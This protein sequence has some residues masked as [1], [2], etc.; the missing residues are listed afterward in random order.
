MAW[1]GSGALARTSGMGNRSTSSSVAIVCILAAALGITLAGCGDDSGTTR[2]TDGGL[3]DYERLPLECAG[4]AL[5]CSGRNAFECGNGDGC[6]QS[7][8]CRGTPTSVCLGRTEVSCRAEGCTWSDGVGCLDPAMGDCSLYD[9]TGYSDIEQRCDNRDGCTWLDRC[10]G[11]PDDC[12]RYSVSECEDNLCRLGCQPERDVCND[13]CVDLLI[14][15]DHCGDCSNA[16][17]GDGIGCVLGSCGCAPPNYEDTCGVCD[18]DPSNDC[19]EDCAGVWGGS[20]REDMCGT[21]DVNPSNDCVQDCAGVW[22]GSSLMDDC[23]TCDNSA[24]NDCDCAGVPGGNST[25]D[26][27]GVCDADPMNDCDCSGVP[28][29]PATLDNCGVCDADPMN[30]CVQDCSGTWGGTAY[31]DPCGICDANPG[32][33][34][35]PCAGVGALGSCWYLG[36]DDESCA[37][38]CAMH[39]AFD[40]ATASIAGSGGSNGECQTVL[41]ALGH[42]GVVVNDG[43][44]LAQYSHLGCT[45]ETAGGMLRARY[46]GYATWDTAHYTGIRRACACTE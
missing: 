4:S 40:D 34:C 41:T 26:P 6:I 23:G 21:C 10:V 16:C 44:T 19:Q 43:T 33:D 22:G 18:A 24:A 25:V 28:M 36:T 8:A 27:C 17:V 15:P 29:G 2:D 13:E 46:N 9:D 14:D 35:P 20:S 30:D 7:G 1:L 3:S 45:V 5:S 31:V 39:G 37:A 42:P 32:N 38:L 11:V 12:S